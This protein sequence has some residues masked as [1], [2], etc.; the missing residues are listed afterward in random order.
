MGIKLKL[1]KKL[2]LKAQAILDSTGEKSPLFLSKNNIGI[3]TQKYP[4][5]KLHIID[6]P[7]DSNGNTLILGDTS[8]S[9]LRLGFHTNYAWIQSHG[10]KPLFINELGNNTIVNLEGGSLGIGTKTPTQKLE[11][12]GSIQAKRLLLSEVESIS[13]KDEVS[14]LSIDTNGEIYNNNF[15][16]LEFEKLKLRLNEVE[17]ENK[18]LQKIHKM[19]G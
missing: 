13:N 3:G 4:K 17:K 6:N 10:L 18:R 1:K 2:E 16:V 15:L 14:F 19:K 8:S 9:N 7:R 5:G 11:V 12:N